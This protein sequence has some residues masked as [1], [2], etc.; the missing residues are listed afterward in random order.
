MRSRDSVCGEYLLLNKNNYCFFNMF[1]NSCLI[2]IKLL[3]KNVKTMIEELN[4]ARSG[5]CF[6][7]AILY[8]HVT[9]SVGSTVPNY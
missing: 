3:N 2:V 5:S 8:V 9:P 6:G 7:A 1:N 4:N